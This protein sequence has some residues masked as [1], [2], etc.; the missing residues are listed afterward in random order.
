MNSGPLWPFLLFAGLVVGLVLF[1][2]G[3]SHVLGGRRRD[4]VTEEPYESGMPLTGSAHLRLSIKYYLIA[5]F[6]VLFDLE[7]I[8]L[9]TWAVAV[10]E[11]AWAGFAAMAFFVVALLIALVYLW[12][13]GALEWDRGQTGNSEQ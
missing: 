13:D 1:M 9:I 8:F 7:T 3:A 2:L 4:R 6:F 5:M 10:R 11:V 12:R